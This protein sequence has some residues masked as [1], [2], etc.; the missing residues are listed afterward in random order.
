MD[1]RVIYHLLIPSLRFDPGDETDTDT[2]EEGTEEGIVII[3][4]TAIIMT[5]EE[6]TENGEQVEDTEQKVT[7]MILI[8]MITRKGE[9][10]V[11]GKKGK[12]VRKGKENQKDQRA[13]ILA[14]RTTVHRILNQSKLYFIF[15]HYVYSYLII[16]KLW[17]YSY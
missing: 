10:E 3:L 2:Q 17:Y 15:N 9:V 1:E 4:I 11:Q 16:L 6:G 8:M 14:Q 7:H 13:V 5:E 12:T